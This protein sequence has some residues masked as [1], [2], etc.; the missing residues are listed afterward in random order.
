MAQRLALDSV[1]WS[2]SGDLSLLKLDLVVPNWQAEELF[3]YQVV[4]IFSYLRDEDF[5]C[6]PATAMIP[7]LM[8]LFSIPSFMSN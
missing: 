3:H 1:W 6:G 8:L 2:A 4:V 5:L 7:N